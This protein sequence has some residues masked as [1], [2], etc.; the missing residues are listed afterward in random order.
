MIILNDATFS[1]IFIY[2][3]FNE[4]PTMFDVSRNAIQHYL[5]LLVRDTVFNVHFVIPNQFKMISCVFAVNYDL[6]KEEENRWDKTTS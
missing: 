3:D 1:K 6:T 5:F 2:F 4:R